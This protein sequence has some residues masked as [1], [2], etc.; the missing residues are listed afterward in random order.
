MAEIDLPDGYE[1]QPG[2][3]DLIDD[4]AGLTRSASLDEGGRPGWTADDLR[5]WWGNDHFDIHDDVLVVCNG[6]GEIVGSEF[7]DNRE[8][9]VRIV[10]LGGVH[11]AH[12]NRGLGSAMLAWADARALEQV[13]KAPAHARITT[14]S[15]VFANHAPSIAL[16]ADTGRE[17]RR[18]FIEM[19]IQLDE[20]PRDAS[21]PTGITVRNFVPGD[22][23]HVTAA[24]VQTAFRDHYGHI[25]APDDVY[26]K[27]F[28]QDMEHPDF[29]ASLWWLAEVD[30]QI[31]GANLCHGSNEGDPDQGYVETLAVLR[32]WR[33]RGLGRALL[34]LAFHELK[35]R[36]KHSVAL[37]VDAESLTGATR[38]Y[39]SVGMREVA[40]QADYGKELRPGEDLRTHD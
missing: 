14:E 19:E 10:C 39:E 20:P 9:F 40:R 35:R 13:E 25:D 33:G 7:V 16:M 3:T 8:P 38:L 5:N 28:R 36:G 6:A 18:Y 2:S 24:L 23:D 29:D 30:G 1:A 32:D 12:R 31:V 11:P 15:W 17:L 34:L 26:L 4:I 22:D 27:R 37:G 21:L